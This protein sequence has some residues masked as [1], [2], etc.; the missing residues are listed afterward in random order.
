LTILLIFK[1]LDLFLKLFLKDENK[2]AQRAIKNKAPAKTSVP[3]NQPIILENKGE[4]EKLAE[5]KAKKIMTQ[6]NHPK[7]NFPELSFT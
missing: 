1:D 4:L 6:I 7:K 2:E 5:I 3:I